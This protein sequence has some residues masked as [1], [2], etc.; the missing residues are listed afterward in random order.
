MSLMAAAIVTSSVVGAVGSNMAAGEQADA[1]ERGQDIQQ[2]GAVQGVKAITDSTGE[3]ITTLNNS[4][5]ESDQQ[6]RDSAN[7]QLDIQRDAGTRSA[8]LIRDG[9]LAARDAIITA[10]NGSIADITQGRNAAIGAQQ[11]F[12]D[13]GTST[14]PGLQSLIN[15]PN[16]QRDFIT[17]N[18]FYDSLAADAQDRLFNN[19]AAR[20]KVGSGGTAA[21]L[22]NQLVLMGSDLLNNN[23]AQRFGL[24]QIG[25][26]AA[27]QIGAYNTNAATQTA[28][29]RSE[30]GVNIGNLETGVRNNMAS[31]IQGTANNTSNILDTSMSRITGLNSQTA[32]NIA[33]LQ[34]G[35]GNNIAN[36]W[37]G[38][39]TN[40]ANLE[41]AKGDAQ[42][43]GIVG[44]VNALN[45][46][47]SNFL[48]YKAMQTPPYVPGNTV[49]T[50][51][52]DY[53]RYA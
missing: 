43:A 16:A 21:S 11:P 15:D 29:I 5:L 41:I 26:N 34:S 2:A 36:V 30:A 31:A 18:P 28:G 7:Q 45:G 35:M 53:S 32:N 25:Q 8:D 47:I 10:R 20:G 40:Q 9:G 1:A 13:A 42:A 48:T 39:A 50:P 38:N 12:Y 14:L 19:Q 17:N 51:N 4:H 27:N 37:T 33:G 44:P 24:A 3:A 23:I 49:G 46:G 22:Q 6:L 52:T